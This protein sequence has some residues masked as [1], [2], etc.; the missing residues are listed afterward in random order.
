MKTTASYLRVTGFMI[1]AFILLEI[2]VESGESW[3]IVQYPIIWAILAMVLFFAIAL[4]IIAA[5]LHRIL[6]AG[7]S[8]EAKANYIA[9]ETLRD[10]NRFAWFK[11]KYKAMLGAKPIAN[12]QEIV[13]DHNYDG[14]REL[15]NNLPPWWTW[16]FY[17]SIVFAVVYFV[18]YEVFDGPSQ[19]DEYEMELAQAKQDIEEFK[20]N[21]KDL[22]DVNTVELLTEP[23]DLAAGEAVFVAN[24]VACHK[25]SGGGGIGPNLTDDYWI[26]GG[27]IKNIFNTISEGGRAGKGMVAWKTDLKPNEMA[28]V[29]S[30]VLTLHGTNPVDPKE[31]EGDIWM[32]ENA[33][34]DNVDVKIIDSTSIKIEMSNDAKIESIVSGN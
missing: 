18:Y 3:A 23:S 34:V 1:L 20:K 12:E 7:L 11:R 4:E 33:P 10:Q 22:I 5:A 30:Y 9:T 14:I 32:D 15:D 2:I 21:N 31:P 25:A 17:I 8:A 27:G 29:A 24:C 26:L 6:F 16:L 13:L 19:L 28:Q